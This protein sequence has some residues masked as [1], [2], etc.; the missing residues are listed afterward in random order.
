MKREGILF[1]LKGEEEKNP[2]IIE[3]RVFTTLAANAEGGAR[4]KSFK[5][6]RNG[7]RG[8]KRENKSWKILLL[9]FH[10]Q[11]RSFHPYSIKK[12]H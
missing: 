2:L 6:R 4:G 12:S 9:S 3:K 1:I 10:P 11:K 7:L 8:R 5:K